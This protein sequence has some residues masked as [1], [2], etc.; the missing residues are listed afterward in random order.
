MRKLKSHKALII[1]CC[2]FAYIVLRYLIGLNTCDDKMWKECGDSCLPDFIWIYDPSYYEEYD[3]DLFIRQGPFLKRYNET[4]A[5]IIWF[6]YHYAVV[7]ST[8]D[9]IIVEYCLK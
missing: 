3:P 6:Y 2:I 4:Q 5:I 1:I 9:K 7:Y 8:K